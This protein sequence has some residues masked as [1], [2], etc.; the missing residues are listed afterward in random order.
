MQ[1]PEQINLVQQLMTMGEEDDMDDD[2]E[3]EDGAV[4]IVHAMQPGGVHLGTVDGLL[5]EFE[6]LFEGIGCLK[7][8]LMHVH[9]D[10]AVQ[11][12]ALKHCQVAFH[13]RPKVEAELRKLEQEDI[14]WV[15]PIVIAHKT[16]KPGEDL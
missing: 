15:S 3:E 5:A 13:L 7:D 8:R 14:I 16:K 6:Q 9:I 2:D 1:K 4:Y 12:F 11:P 10:K